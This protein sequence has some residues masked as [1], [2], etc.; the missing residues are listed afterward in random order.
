MQRGNNEARAAVGAPRAVFGPM[1]N[2]AMFG[3]SAPKRLAAT[4]ED[5]I[6]KIVEREPTDE[7]GNGEDGGAF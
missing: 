6:A 2:V 3:A 1:V 5:P 4:T 7:C